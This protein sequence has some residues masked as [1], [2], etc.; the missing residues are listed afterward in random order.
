[1]SCQRTVKTF[2]TVEV[3]IDTC[4]KK[5]LE[6]LEQSIIS[7][8]NQKLEKL[9]ILIKNCDIYSNGNCILVH[10]RFNICSSL[11]EVAEAFGLECELVDCSLKGKTYLISDQLLHVLKQID[12]QFNFGSN[13]SNKDLV[14]EIEDIMGEFGTTKIDPDILEMV[15]NIKKN[16]V[17]T[18]SKTREVSQTFYDGRLIGHS[19]GEWST[20]ENVIRDRLLK[21]SKDAESVVKKTNMNLRDGTTKLIYTRAK[22]M[23]YAVQ[24]VKKGTQTQLVL[25]RYE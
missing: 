17:Y 21:M 23:G 13:V 11:K 14:D 25:V 10:D 19:E 16:G 15:R 1:M 7:S 8:T 3:K 6:E 18:T 9:N 12:V 22:Q 5:E 20:D 2:E 24:E 4:N